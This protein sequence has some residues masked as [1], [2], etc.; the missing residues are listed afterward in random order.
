[1]QIDAGS[2]LKVSLYVAGALGYRIRAFTPDS[3]ANT[4]Q[5]SI[6]VERMTEA[7]IDDLDSGTLYRFTVASIGFQEQVSPASEFV[8]GIT[9]K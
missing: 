6:R 7:L 8:T 5:K 9:C 4:K 2:L 3:T 1:M